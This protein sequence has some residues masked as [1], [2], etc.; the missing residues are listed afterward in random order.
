MSSIQRVRR[1]VLAVV[2]ASATAILLTVPASARADDTYAAIA[3]SPKTGAYGYG[4]EFDTRGKAEKKALAECKGDDAELVAWVKNGWCV[5]AVGDD[6]KYGYGTN[7][8]LDVARKT[9]L[10][11][12][13]KITK[14]SHILI[15]VSSDGKVKK[16]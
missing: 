11:E 5:L 6:A 10:E 8:D 16:E 4:F 13:T 2:C 1:F 12:C 7:A 15:C 9:A 3:Y 14:N